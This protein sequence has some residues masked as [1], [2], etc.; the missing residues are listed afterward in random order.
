MF[1]FAGSRPSC[2]PP[3]RSVSGCQQSFSCSP[4]PAWLT[5]GLRQ[6]RWQPRLRR[7]AAHQPRRLVAWQEWTRFGRSTVVYG[8]AAN[9]YINRAGIN[10]HSEPLTSR[11]GDYWGSCGHPEWNGRTSGRPW[12]GAFVAWVMTKSGVSAARLP[13]RRPPRQYLTVALRPRAQRPRRELRAACA[14]RICAQ[15]G[16]PGLHRHRR[17]DLA[18]RR[19]AH[20]AAAHRQ[21]GEPLRRRHRR[22]RRLRPGDR[23]QREEQRHHEPLSRRF[24]RPAAPI[25]GQALDDG[26]REPRDLIA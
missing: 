11:V 25:A 7:S 5:G 23:R 22:A 24:A 20:R 12:S 4:S 21:H 6:Q 14:Q 9:G 3:M 10:E 8:G 26:G 15:G 19:F 16:R 17:P 13:A 2:V 1:V 18:P